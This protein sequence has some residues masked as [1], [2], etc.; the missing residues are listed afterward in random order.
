M[1]NTHP[2][3][4]EAQARKERDDKL[5]KDLTDKYRL[6]FLH[7]AP[8]KEHGIRG[9]TVAY[10]VDRRNVVHVATTVCHP[11]DGFNRKTGE[12]QAAANFHEGH[13]ITVHVPLHIF[14]TV[15]VWI[16]N[17]FQV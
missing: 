12:L 10:V 17:A 9:I 7:R 13:G 11:N 6:K 2:K 5:R 8:M 15:E 14:G 3:A 1:S 4:L 16:K